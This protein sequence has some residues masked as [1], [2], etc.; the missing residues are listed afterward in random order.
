MTNTCHEY[1]HDYTTLSASLRELTKKE[2]S[3]PMDV[4]PS[5]QMK[6]KLTQT[7]VMAYFDTSKRTMVIVD[8]LLVGISAILAQKE[9]DRQQYKI[10]SYASRPLTPIKKRYSQTLRPSMGHLTL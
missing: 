1:I 6:K 7:P 4:S 8:R 5:E 10:I 2:C 9:K 3:F